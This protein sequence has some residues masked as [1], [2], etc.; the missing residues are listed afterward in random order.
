MKTKSD[1]VRRLLIVLVLLTPALATYGL[2]SVL[3][4][5]AISSFVPT[6]SDEVSYWR[7]MLAFREVGLAGGYHSYE[8]Q[9]PPSADFVRFGFH[10][11]AFPVL[12]GMLYRL[13]GR[14]PYWGIVLNVALLTAA[15][16]LFIYG[17]KPDARQLLM[18]NAV[19]ITFWPMLLYITTW[20]QEGVRQAIAIVLSVIFYRLLAADRS[21]PLRLGYLALV[22][23]LIASLFNP[24]WSFMALPVF[25]F[26][27]RRTLRGVLIAAAKTAA[28]VLAMFALFSWW[29]AP[30]YANEYS[31]AVNVARAFSGSLSRGLLSA[32]GIV[33]ENA[34][35][36]RR[37]SL[38][39]LEVL[40]RFQALLLL[41]LAALGGLSMLKAR[42]SDDPPEALKEP[43]FHLFN[44][45]FPLAFTF[46]LYTPSVDYRPLAAHLLI[47]LFLLIACRRFWLVGLIVGSSALFA[48]NFAFMYRQ[49]PAANFDAARHR[50]FEVAQ[51]SLDK[52][53]SFD[54]NQDAWCN[55]LLSAASPFSPLEAAA[56]PPGIGYSVTLHPD[57]LQLPIKS[58][59]VLVDPDNQRLP[60]EQMHLELLKST[61][62]GDLYLNLDAPCR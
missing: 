37:S 24:A 13:L 26:Y 27:E 60:V 52:I 23:V 33:L 17:V 18:V 57:R 55:T 48:P 2:I 34:I 10:G 20:M 41:A 21:P 1:F 12:Y 49:W 19:L 5:A 50:E 25:A 14:A 61:P 47:S 35:L 53:V 59:Y 62:V 11:P 51:D 32:L 22:L 42:K 7:E 46:F 28:I 38:N 6:A 15:L 31:S 39:G 40:Q 45:A 29:S 58:K 43:L 30:Y 4:S 44:L 54:S 36:F 8:E 3:A 56:I 9:P 16:G